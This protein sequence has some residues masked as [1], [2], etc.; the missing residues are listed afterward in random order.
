M[1]HLMEIHEFPTH[2][3]LHL[4]IHM[5]PWPWNKLNGKGSDIFGYRYSGIKL[6]YSQNMKIAA[7][8]VHADTAYLKY[9]TDGKIKT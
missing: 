2:F 4:G 5:N 1:L 8:H 7:N 9:N 6:E 3:A